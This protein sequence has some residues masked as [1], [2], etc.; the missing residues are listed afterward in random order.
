MHLGYWGILKF[1]RKKSSRKRKTEAE[2]IFFNPFIG[3]S[4]YKQKLVFCPFVDEE[5]NGSYPFEN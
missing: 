4:S 5:T 3:C 1:L 2:M